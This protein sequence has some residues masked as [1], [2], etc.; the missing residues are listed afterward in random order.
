MHEMLDDL[1]SKT[2]LELNISENK[3]YL[4]FITN[5]GIFYYHTYGDCFS[6]IW[7]EHLTGTQFLIGNTVRNAF[8]VDLGADL[9]AN[10][11]DYAQNY[12][13]CLSTDKGTFE[14]EYINECDDCYV[15]C[16][17][18]HDEGAVE[19]IQ[20]KNKFNPATDF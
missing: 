3:E 18:D 17:Y 5:N 15:G 6:P 4:Q 1:L 7:I 12:R 13:T 10:N 14:I 11:C 16:I 19:I 9:D 20:S 8:D 2:I